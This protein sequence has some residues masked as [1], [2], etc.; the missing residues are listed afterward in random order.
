MT[1][2]EEKSMNEFFASA[3]AEPMMTLETLNDDLENGQDREDK[4][5][6]SLK[7]TST[8]DTLLMELEH[9]ELSVPHCSDELLASKQKVSKQ[10]PVCNDSTDKTKN[11]GR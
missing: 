4:V 7:Y 2:N 9:M 11:S 8:C 3:D 6:D 5:A 10:C 1:K